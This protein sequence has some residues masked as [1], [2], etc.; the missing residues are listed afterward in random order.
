MFL[1]EGSTDENPNRVKILFYGQSIIQ[2][3]NTESVINTLKER[4]PTAIIEH[5]NRAIGGFQAPNLV[6]VA[7][8]DLY[9][10]Y[11]D[12]MI[13]HVYGGEETGEFE[14]IIRNTRKYTTSEIMLLTHHYAWEKDPEKMVEQTRKDDISSEFIRGIAKKYNCELVD[15]RLGWKAYLEAHPEIG[16][17]NLMGNEVSS[18]VHPN[19]KGNK[20]LELLLL[21]HFRVY[22]AEGNHPW[23][24]TVTTVDLTNQMATDGAGRINPN[25]E[26][27][28]KLGSESIELGF[29][30]N[31]VELIAF[32]SSSDNYGGLDVFIDGK[33]PSEIPELYYATR[34]SRSHTHWRPALKRVTLGDNPTLETWSLEITS[35]DHENR[36]LEF[37]VG[38]TK[39]GFDGKGNNKDVFVS[40]S[41]MIIIEPSDFFIFEADDYTR[42]PTPVGFEI[43]WE[44]MPL[45]QDQI[46]YDPD[47]PI[48]LL[49]QGLKNK[50]HKLQLIYQG[51]TARFPIK[52]LRIYSP[53]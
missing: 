51:N 47:Q 5:E 33:K 38:G 15:I 49:A 8:H 50:E 11:P 46:S 27:A 48:Y 3:M 1:L 35:I 7:T 28:L 53:P 12:L 26:P 43:T 23:A 13:F 41:G 36:Y 52:A 17:N 32:T 29:S 14:E 39:T 16:I 31:R 21:R 44:I 22:N 4:Y 9:P 45:F 10:Y 40:E 24:K 19:K 6:R 37:Q 2:S 34:P 25:T 42:R 30:G 18:D 20:L